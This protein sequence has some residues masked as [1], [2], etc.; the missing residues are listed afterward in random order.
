MT[1]PEL[2]TLQLGLDLSD[3]FGA[4]FSIYLHDFAYFLELLLVLE[5]D[6]IY[7]YRRLSKPFTLYHPCLHRPNARRSTVQRHE[8]MTY[9]QVNKEAYFPLDLTLDQR[10]FLLFQE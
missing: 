10:N 6:G 8:M 5:V 9:L 2:Q 3:C 7:V 1:Q 4:A